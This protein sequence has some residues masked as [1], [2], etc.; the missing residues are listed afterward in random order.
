MN[1]KLSS[2]IPPGLTYIE[3]SR[4]LGLPYQTARLA[5]KRERYRAVDGRQYSQR[6]ERKIRT[7]D[8]DWKQSNI[9]IARQCGVSRE[10]VRFLRE[11]LG[12]PMVESRGR[13]KVALSY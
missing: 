11:K 3:A 12:K 5:L 7:E 13:K 6:G 10:R 8:V 1:A 9:E 4:R 2:R